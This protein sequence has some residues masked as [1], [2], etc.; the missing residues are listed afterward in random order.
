M[1]EA[2]GMPAKEP[3][4]E[5]DASFSSDGATPTGWAEGRRRI[6]EGE[7][8]WLSTV[9]PAWGA[10]MSRVWLSGSTVG[11]GAA[12]EARREL[13]LV[14]APASQPLRQLVAVDPVEAA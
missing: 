3:V 8:F 5:L 12:H 9:R 7:V 6:E 14:G 4:T 11:V 13:S 2:D 1:S 10:R